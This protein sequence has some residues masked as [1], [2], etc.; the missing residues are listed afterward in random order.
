M[1]E[2]V[3]SGGNANVAQVGRVT[4]GGSATNADVTTVTLTDHEGK[5]H[6]ISYTS[7]ASPSDAETVA[8]LVAAAAVAKTG[9]AD[10]WKDV[11]CADAT[12]YMSITAD[13]A[14]NPFTAS[15]AVSGTATVADATSTSNAGPCI[16]SAA[17]NWVGNVAP[18]DGD[19]IVIPASV[20]T[21]IYGEDVTAAQY[22]GFTIEEGYSGNIGAMNKP[23]QIDLEDDSTDY[24]LVSYGTGDI[25]LD[26]DN[27]SYIDIRDAG[28]ADPSSG[29][30]GFNLRGVLSSTSAGV[31]YVR[32]PRG[33]SVSLGGNPGETL[34]AESVT[35]W[36]GTVLFGDGVVDKAAAAFPLLTVEGGSVTLKSP[37]KTVNVKKGSFTREGASA[38]AT[39]LNVEG[40]VVYDNATGTILLVNIYGAGRLDA[41]RN[42]AGATYTAVEMWESA[43]FIDPYKKIT[44]TDGINLNKRGTK[45][46]G[47]ELGT[48]L[49]IT[50]AAVS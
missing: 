31:I 26:V 29:E 4:P 40:G 19:S 34:E 17:E 46:P 49:K 36:S 42:V 47:L 25:F 30:Y 9:D 1:S 20:T 28:S 33:R 3:F 23:L 5:V 27:Y 45:A 44:L 12:T 48:D 43:A 18:V 41:T 15:S 22:V 8:G 11:T 35:V 7:D 16:F 38:I 50:R 2:L 10:A 6:A 32:C 13:T 14:G 39:A 24:P 21:N 37:C